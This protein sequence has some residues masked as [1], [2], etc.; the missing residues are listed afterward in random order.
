MPSEPDDKP[1][2]QS[3]VE[4]MINALDEVQ[5]AVERLAAE[6]RRSGRP[7]VRDSVLLEPFSRDD[8]SR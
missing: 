3:P 7:V 2:A 4:R 6:T 5:E 8:S 1:H